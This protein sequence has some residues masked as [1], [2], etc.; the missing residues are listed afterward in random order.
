MKTSL[1]FLVLIPVVLLVGCSTTTVIEKRISKYPELFAQLSEDHQLLVRQGRVQEGMNRNAV[2]LA[3]GPADNITQ[4]SKDGKAV[5]TWLYGGGYTDYNS[6]RFNVGYG[7][8]GYGRGGGHFGYGVNF[9]IGPNTHYHGDPSARA[10]FT[11][12][13][14]S[15]WQSAMR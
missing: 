1:K 15:E 6:P 9:P 13:I 7:Y 2:F 10:V 5:E 12:G 14:V 8:G 3:W 4:G 11:N